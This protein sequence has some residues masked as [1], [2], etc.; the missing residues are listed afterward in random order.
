[1]RCTQHIVGYD[2]SPICV[3]MRIK[4]MEIR[5]PQQRYSSDIDPFCPQAGQILI[6]PHTAARTQRSVPGKGKNFQKAIPFAASHD[7]H[8]IRSP[9]QHTSFPANSR[10][11]LTK[12]A[13]RALGAVMG[14]PNPLCDTRADKATALSG[15]ADPRLRPPRGLCS[16]AAT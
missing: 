4:S 13:Y 11:A 12:A 1:M 2:P 16:K 10:T 15:V 5:I 14:S 7:F 9:P 6:G 3:L 8:A